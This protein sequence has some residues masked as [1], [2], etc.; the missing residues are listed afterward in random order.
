MSGQRAS[1]AGLD[2]AAASGQ[3]APAHNTSAAEAAAAAAAAVAAIP[4]SAGSAA[5]SQY[6]HGAAAYPAG[7]MPTLQNDPSL[8]GPPPQSAGGYAA[9]HQTYH[10]PPNAGIADPQCKLFVG[11][12]PNSMDDSMLH[13][14]FSHYGQVHQAEVMKHRDS[15][16]SRGFGFVHMQTREQAAGAIS[17]LNGYRMD[18]RILQVSVKV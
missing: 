14:L 10:P 6:P 2:S 16:L 11:H 15:G 12:L 17:A 9:V 13:G 3:H 7:T 4:G 18:G 5:A 8:P 1:T